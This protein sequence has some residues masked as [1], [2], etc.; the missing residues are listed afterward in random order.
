[1]QSALA[2]ILLASAVVCA[3]SSSSS[4]SLSQGSTCDGNPSGCPAGTTCWPADTTPDAGA[5]TLRCLNSSPLNGFGASCEEAIGQPSC[6]DGLACDQTG[7]NALGKCTYY[8]DGAGHG[9]PPGYECRETHVG[10]A[11]GPAIDICR[12]GMLFMDA[13]PPVDD[14]ACTACYDALFT[15][16]DAGDG[17]PAMK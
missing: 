6:G 3:C 17:G 16:V 9:C 5:P 4:P 2:G 10:S 7:P 12:P 15:P 1:M 11:T 8:C 14:G 13:T